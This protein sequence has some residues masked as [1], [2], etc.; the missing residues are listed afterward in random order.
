MHA[1]ARQAYT[2][3][4]KATG[5]D[6]DDGPALDRHRSHGRHSTSGRR[7]QLHGLPVRCPTHYVRIYIRVYTQVMV[8]VIVAGSIP[9]ACAGS[10]GIIGFLLSLSLLPSASI[11]APCIPST[12]LYYISFGSRSPSCMCLRPSLFK[13]NN[14]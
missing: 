6:D 13:T 3:R 12:T 2:A 4:A 5:Q 7:R 8:I 11:V 9:H 1:F 10:I 14:L